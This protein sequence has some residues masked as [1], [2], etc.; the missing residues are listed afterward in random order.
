MFIILEGAD[1]CGKD[2]LIYGMR[3]LIHNPKILVHH[4]GTPPKGVDPKLWSKLYYTYLLKVS[5]DMVN[6]GGVVIA[7]R[8]HLGETVY[9]PL[10]R[11]TDDE[12]VWALEKLFKVETTALIL[13][14]DKPENILARDDGISTGSTLQNFTDVVN[15]F[16]AAFEKTA[17]QN[18]IRWDISE[19][20]WPDPATILK[21]IHY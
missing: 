4:S 21:R 5:Q 12:Y 18:K 3:K 16:D 19:L 14:T 20:G 10:F 11:N 17:I 7:N 15:R 2:T 13:M 1:R 8:C 9:G 6:D